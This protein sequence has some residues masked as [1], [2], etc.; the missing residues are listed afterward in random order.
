LVLAN[1]S[2]VPE[3]S[4]S[5]VEGSSTGRLA[6]E[7]ISGAVVQLG[8]LNFGSFG[9]GSAGS[10]GLGNVGHLKPRPSSSTIASSCTLVATRDDRFTG[11]NSASDPSNGNESFRSTLGKSLTCA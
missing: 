7:D 2:F 11:G 6:A 9:L 4:F 8:K 3:L 10:F 5:Q 1:R